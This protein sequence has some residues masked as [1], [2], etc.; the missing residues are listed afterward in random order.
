MYPVEGDITFFFS[1][2][3]FFFF[4]V[5]I[6]TWAEMLIVLLKVSFLSWNW[7]GWTVSLF[8]FFVFF[9]FKCATADSSAFDHVTVGGL[10]NLKKSIWG[11]ISRPTKR[12][13]LQNCFQQRYKGSLIAGGNYVCG[14]VWGLGPQ[15]CV[16]SFGLVSCHDKLNVFPINDASSCRDFDPRKFWLLHG[17]WFGISLSWETCFIISSETKLGGGGSP[18]VRCV[19]WCPVND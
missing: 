6:Q 14:C 2:F 10:R 18:D 17:V 5:N 1:S 19:G 7:F 9:F 4:L 13:E 16:F 11:K 8:C 15:G 12:C 3:S